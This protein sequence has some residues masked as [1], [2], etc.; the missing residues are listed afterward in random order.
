MRIFRDQVFSRADLLAALAVTCVV[1]GWVGAQEVDPVG[2]PEPNEGVQSMSPKD[3]NAETAEEPG[4]GPMYF[5]EEMLDEFELKTTGTDEGNVLPPVA[6]P[7][8]I[9]AA[10]GEGAGADAPGSDV[11]ASL[12]AS[13]YDQFARPVEEE[14]TEE[15]IA[16]TDLTN[17]VSYIDRLFSSQE[18]LEQLLGTDAVFIY[19]SEGRRDPMILPWIR[20]EFDIR[21]TMEFAHAAEEAG[22]LQDALAAYQTI[23]NEYSGSRA[24]GEAAEAVGRIEAQIRIMAVGGGITEPQYYLPQEISEGLT[25]I[26]YD[27]TQP[28]CLIGDNIFGEGDTIPNFDVTILE[29]RES[30]VVFLYREKE[31]IVSVAVN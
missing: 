22:R 20:R 12:E 21:Q 3:L 28:N 30:E 25:G 31:F 1:A 27:A 8:V 10:D 19:D 7:Q 29:I 15:L 17:E 26:L 4:Q 11:A 9:P 5:S 24:A 6:A 23:V 2:T 14:I 13:P 16:A 18:Q